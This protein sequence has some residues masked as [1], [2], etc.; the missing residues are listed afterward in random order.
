ML[1]KV[2]T[3]FDTIDFSSCVVSIG[4][5]DGVH[6]GHQALLNQLSK[7]KK[8]YKT[9]SVVISFDP[10]P[11]EFFKK[12]PFRLFSVDD[13]KLQLIKLHIDYLFLLKFDQNMA[14]LNPI[15]FLDQKI[16][17]LNPKAIVV[18]QDFCFGQKAL[19]T[20]NTLKY[21]AK[22]K[23][24]EVDIFPDIYWKSKK[25]SSS[26]LRLCYQN[27]QKKELEDLLG[28]SFPKI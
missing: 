4:N 19:G 9:V 13:L 21:W 14:S 28:R 6:I 27:N 22:D 5:F 26:R 8:K 20:V 25:V 11:L 2:F 17:T 16:H 15:E 3:N 24:L 7:K 1:I 10:H 23:D 12:K 18:G